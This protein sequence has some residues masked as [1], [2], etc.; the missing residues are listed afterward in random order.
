[1]RTTSCAVK[2]AGTTNRG[3]GVCVAREEREGCDGDVPQPAIR[4]Q[5]ARVEKIGLVIALF[6]GDRDRRIQTPDV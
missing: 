5:I 2:P 1:M 6:S 4:T 3:A